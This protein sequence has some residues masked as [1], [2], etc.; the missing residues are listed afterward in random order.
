VALDIGVKELSTKTLP[1]KTSAKRPSG[2][3]ASTAQ[4]GRGSRKRGINLCL[5]LSAPAGLNSESSSAFAEN[6]S[7]IQRVPASNPFGFA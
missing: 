7:S 5:D 4:T 6:K 3:K 1:R 2:S